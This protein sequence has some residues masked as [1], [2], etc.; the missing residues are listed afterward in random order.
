MTPKNIPSRKPK[1]ELRASPLALKVILTLLI[2]FSMA[3]LVALRWVHQDIQ[4]E[5]G[6]LKAQAAQIEYDNEILEKRTKNM[7][8]VD[9]IEEIARD[10]LGLVDPGTV[11]LKPQ[12]APTTSQPES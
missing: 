1:V 9:T 2:L 6:A 11:V 5:I 10:E 12:S 7:G 3:A 8:S 4:N